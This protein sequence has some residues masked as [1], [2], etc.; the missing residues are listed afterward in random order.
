M[1]SIDVVKKLKR[2]QSVR[3]SIS[4]ESCYALITD[5]TEE[6][7]SLIS[8]SGT[9]YSLAFSDMGTVWEAEAIP[10]FTDVDSVSYTRTSDVLK[11]L[12]DMQ[13]SAAKCTGF[14]VGMVTQA[15]VI[16]DMLG[17]VIQKLG[18]KPYVIKDGKLYD[19]EED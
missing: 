1:L 15:W 5:I 13:L 3:L 2:G 9:K 16:S 11:M 6:K 4:N 12:K 18:G 8:E 17:P 7:I 10:S 19:S 14:I